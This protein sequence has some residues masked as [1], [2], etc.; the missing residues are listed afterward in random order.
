MPR[1]NLTDV[2]VRKAA[3][4]HTGTKELWDEAVRGL[5]FRLTPNGRRYWFIRYRTPSGQRRYK[6]GEYPGL[7]LAD[8]RKDARSLLAEIDKGA[9][10]QREKV[11]RRIATAPATVKDV[12]ERYIGEVKGRNR[13]WKETERILTRHAID[14]WGPRLLEDVRRADVIALLDDLAKTSPYMANSLMRQLR[15]F[16]N[17]TVEKD[18]LPGTPMAGV[19]APHKETSRDRI[20]SDDELSALWSVWNTM[21]YPFGAFFK[22]CALTAQ[23]RSEVAAM[24]W[25]H[26][27]LESK[28]WTLPR[29]MT[30]SDRA[31]E[32]PLSSQV[33]DILKSLPR[34]SC[35]LVFTTNDKTPISGFSRAK[36]Q[37]DL[38]FALASLS[39]KE[40]TRIEKLKGKTREKAI[41]KLPRLA[42]W[43]THDLRRTA[44]SGMARAGIQPHVVEKVLNHATGQISGVAAVYNR[45][46]YLDE[47]RAALNAWGRRI[48]DILPGEKKT[49]AKVVELQAA[50]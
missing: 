14:A 13:S 8:A 48:E 34:W 28:I 4:P 32:V 41:A 21:P 16:F 44:A 1:A 11:N 35:G 17:W 23:R 19:K 36:T 15:R 24:N 29:E 10:P 40:R 25:E 42:P 2:L 37:C 3:P 7:K 30:K 45:H 12:I 31:H 33:V 50:R 5:G 18:I 6:L 49:G 46:G 20:L 39:K 47:K 22:V 9:D 43:R 26:I 38:E 27:D